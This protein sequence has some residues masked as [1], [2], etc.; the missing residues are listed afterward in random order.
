MI[1]VSIKDIN[2]HC[3][4]PEET[5]AS[6]IKKFDSTLCQENNISI[7]VPQISSW[8]P[9]FL[10]TDNQKIINFIKQH[11]KSDSKIIFENPRES[12]LIEKYFYKIH[13]IIE[14]SGLSF[15]RFYFLTC[16]I[17][18]E[19]L[20]NTWLEKNQKKYKI[21]IISVS[22][23]ERDV[24]INSFS[25]VGKIIK[26]KVC[27]K[28]KKFLCFNRNNQIHKFA[29]LMMLKHHD[30][31]QDGFVS[32]FANY[33]DQNS[34]VELNAF[35]KAMSFHFKH[36]NLIKTIL[37]SYEQIKD[38]L[39]MELDSKLRF[40]QNYPTV[41][42][43]KYFNNSY[44]SVV[45]EKVFFEDTGPDSIC[46]NY[47]TAETF[48]PIVMMHP[49]ILMAWPG[50]LAYLRKLGYQTFQG[51]IDET[52]D[53]IEN[54]TD[55]FLAILNE[56]QRLCAFSDC[57]FLKWQSNIEPIVRHNFRVLQNKCS[58]ENFIVERI[59]AALI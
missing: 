11:L 33:F 22:F 24:R 30:L 59:D 27:S 32:F 55:R 21:N 4:P 35:I 41:Y 48:K 39:P 9:G 23:W 19:N 16:C 42:D 56:I 20:Y 17:D 7:R 2:D 58:P 18:V 44:F 38:D 6:H 5:N 54:S 45:T 12:T 13:Q 34:T 40:V 8:V 46:Q 53:T 10:N 28:Q 43:L 26:Y 36:D 50:S 25:T 3:F 37:N 49:F 29:L 31:V 52:Y 14:D 57:E 51:H 15:S 47:F 1:Q